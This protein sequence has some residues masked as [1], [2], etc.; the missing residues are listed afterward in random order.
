[1]FDPPNPEAAAEAEKGAGGSPD[2]WWLGKCG[3]A[4]F[5]FLSRARG[6]LVSFSV[7]CKV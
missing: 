2:V 4:A 7:C 5:V 3:P 1:M 6:F